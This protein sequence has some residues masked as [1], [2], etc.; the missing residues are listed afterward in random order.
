MPKAEVI[1]ITVPFSKGTLCFSL[2]LALLVSVL[3][4]FGCNGSTG[5]KDLGI[6]PQGRLRVAN[7]KLLDGNGHQVV[8]QGLG[9]GA[10]SSIKALGRWNEDYF[11]NARAWGAGLVRLPVFPFTF[12]ENAEQ[13]LLDLDDA[14]EW[15]QKYDLYLI[16]DYHVMGNASQ[17]Q[18]LYDEFVTWEEI[19][20]FWATVAGRYA[21]IPTV[22]FC[23]IYNE[24]AALDPMSTPWE[25]DDWSKHADALVAVLRKYAPNAIPVVA[26]LD[27][28]Y[29]FSAGGDKPFSDPDIALSAHPYPGKAR[30]SRR[31]AWNANFGYLSDRYPMILTEIGF[32][33]NDSGSYRDDLSYGREI[34][35]YAKDKKISWTAFVF[36]NEPGWPLPLF[37]DWETLTPTV[38]GLFFKDVLSGKDIESAGIP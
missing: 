17:G 27:F 1:K 16:I 30:T 33:P 9:L 8:L 10:L 11:A 36:Y 2:Y 20:N 37:S 26:G 12:R 25:F 22:A 3:G 38:S 7:G 34:L 14:V 19:E 32:D 28:A 18:F 4:L 29:D 31:A 23:E 15:C 5:P 13:L 35:G 24:P 21:D 6:A